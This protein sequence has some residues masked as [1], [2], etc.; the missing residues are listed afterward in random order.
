MRSDPRHAFRETGTY[1]LL[2]TGVAIHNGRRK[3]GFQN[4]IV[5]KSYYAYIDVSMY[6]VQYN[7][8]KDNISTRTLSISV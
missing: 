3:K 1:R 4:R 8:L 5:P 6:T 2:T 7:V